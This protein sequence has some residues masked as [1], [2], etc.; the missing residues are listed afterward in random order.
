[1]KDME[2]SRA[3][4]ILSGNKDRERRAAEALRANLRRRKNQKRQAD[5]V[6]NQVNTT[7]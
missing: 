7:E 6:K 1:M 4:Q 2:E 3:G 5:K